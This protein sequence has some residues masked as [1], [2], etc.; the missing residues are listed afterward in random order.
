MFSE[1]EWAKNDVEKKGYNCGEKKD[2]KITPTCSP[3]LRLMN[4]IFLLP[5]ACGVIYIFTILLPIF[6]TKF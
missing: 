3:S 5:E 6:K 4:A 2:K 1:T